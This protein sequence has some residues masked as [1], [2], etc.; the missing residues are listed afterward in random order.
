MEERHFF[1]IFVIQ[2]KRALGPLAKWPILSRCT[3]DGYI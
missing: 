2:P 3:G 1:V